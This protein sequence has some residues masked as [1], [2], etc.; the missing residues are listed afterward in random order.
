ML[1]V[2]IGSSSRYLIFDNLNPGLR[3][4]SSQ[5]KIIKWGE[6]SDRLYGL[7]RLGFWRIDLAA[8]QQELLFKSFLPDDFLIADGKI[9]YLENQTLWEKNLGSGRNSIVTSPVKCDDCRLTKKIGNRFVLR[10]RTTQKL[11]IIDAANRKNDLENSAKNLYWLN[12]ESLLFY[13]DWEM[14]IY[15]LREP[16]PELITRLGQP[17]KSVLWHPQGKHLIFAADNKIKVIELDNRE[18]RNVIDLSDNTEVKDMAL[19]R[20]GKTLYFSGK[21]NGTEGIYKLILQ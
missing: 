6:T 12:D 3:T 8:K 20:D 21:A 4:I 16:D 1:L 10:R 14:Y 18:L 2:V 17:L 13:N 9:F 7:D 19:S 11:L 15:N 5:F